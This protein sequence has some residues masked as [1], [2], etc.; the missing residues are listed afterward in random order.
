MTLFE[1][2]QLSKRT[3]KTGRDLDADLQDYC[4]GILTEGGEA[5]DVLK[6]HLYHGHE[7]DVERFAKE[8]GDALWYIAAVCTKVGIDLH[9]AHRCAAA[10]I[11]NPE[12]TPIRFFQDAI[13]F[14]ARTIT[15]S[16]FK[17]CPETIA[18][19]TFLAGKLAKTIEAVCG[20]Y[21]IPLAM[22]L[23][24]NVKKLMER[25]PDGFSQAASINR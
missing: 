18:E 8:A 25:Y 1:F 2:Q 15:L 21:G 11:F 14:R 23:E 5:F 7:L 24:N 10:E 13:I 6:K 3:L 12:K 16:L 19:A 4:L 9:C 20:H 17:E 22:V